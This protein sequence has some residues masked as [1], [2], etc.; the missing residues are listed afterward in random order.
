MSSVARAMRFVFMFIMPLCITAIFGARAGLFAAP[1]ALRGA[2]LRRMM[3]RARRAR[4]EAPAR[5]QRE[6][7]NGRARE[8]ISRVRRQVQN[9]MDSKIIPDTIHAFIDKRRGPAR[10]SF[11]AASARVRL[12]MRHEEPA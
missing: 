7:R 3:R 5:L 6:C 12:A 11:L 4:H 2:I 1:G 8:S 10:L 9:K